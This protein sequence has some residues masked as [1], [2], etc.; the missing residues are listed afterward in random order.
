MKKF[1]I[2]SNVHGTKEILLDDE[3]YDLVVNAPCKWYLRRF[4][5]KGK[6]KWYGETKMRGKRLEKFKENFPALHIPPSGCIMM[7]K[8]I[9]NTPKGMHTDHINHDGLD[10]QREN[11]RVCTPSQN[12]Q[13]KR[14]RVD[15]ATGYKG[16]RERKPYPRKYVHTKNGKPTGKIS[17]KTH[18]L[19]K[20]FCAYISDPET[21]NPNKRHII[22]G[23]YYT[24]EEAAMA[25]DTKAL[26][27]YGEFAQLNFP[28]K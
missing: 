12:A 17:Y 22:L 16:V 24:P 8:F 7:H 1:I 28:T 27:I 25:Y 2:I 11:L 19:K 5:S 18:K 23:S 13:N 6:E 10:N 20:K 3:D 9:M 14:L 26:E 4:K 21:S 15:S